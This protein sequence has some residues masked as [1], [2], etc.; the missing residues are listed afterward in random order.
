MTIAWYPERQWD[1]WV[2]DD[3]KKEIEPMF[4]EELKKCLS[5][6]YNMVILNRFAS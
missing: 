4:I 2:S 6:V 5:V 1:W 3:E